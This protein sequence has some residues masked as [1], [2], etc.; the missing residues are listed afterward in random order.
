MQLIRIPKASENLEAATVGKWLKAEGDE[1]RAGEEVVELLTDKADFALEAEESG[2]LR[3]ITAV[4]KST[5]PVG[6]ILGIIA[7]KDEPLPDV[8]PENRALMQAAEL[9]AGT[10]EAGAA[11]RPSFAGRK[12]AATPAARRLAKERGID[13]AEIASALGKKGALTATDVEQYLQ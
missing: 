10:E 12:I 8:D 2:R 4:E 11:P 9:Q 1:V 5:V 7:G 13:L 3:R 6:Y